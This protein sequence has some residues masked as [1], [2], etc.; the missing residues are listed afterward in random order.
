MRADLSHSKFLVI[1]ASRH[2]GRN[3][4]G[5]RSVQRT[6]MRDASLGVFVPRFGYST[7]SSFG[8]ARALGLSLR[9]LHRRLKEQGWTFQGLL[10]AERKHVACSRLREP[11]LSIGE[12]AYMLGYSEQ[13]AFLRAFRRWTGSS[14][15]EFRATALAA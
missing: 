2:I 4:E 7:R 11:R 8:V 13:S 15:S 9:T 5:C 10:D 1:I 6:V 14:P 3:A 12:V